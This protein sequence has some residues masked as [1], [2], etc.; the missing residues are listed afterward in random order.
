MGTIKAGLFISLDGVVESLD[1]WHLPYFN[2]EMAEAVGAMIAGTDGLLLGR[3]TYQEFAGFWPTADPRDP[4]TTVMNGTRKYVVST[5]LTEATWENSTV[6]NGEVAA[7]VARLKRDRQLGM[8]GS[9]TLVRW[10]LEQGLLDELHLLVHPIVI[11]EGR[12]LFGTG[13]GA[14]FGAGRQVPLRLL[15]SFA[16]YTGVLYLI[17]TGSD[18]GRD[19]TRRAIRPSRSPCRPGRVPRRRG[20]SA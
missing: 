11:G 4:F 19:V 15:S 1:A 10:L 9:P 2:D 17:Y 3:R 5:T 16:F 7:E 8:W 13:T 14:G 6:V 12:R 20:R 18:P